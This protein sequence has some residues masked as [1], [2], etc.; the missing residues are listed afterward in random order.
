MLASVLVKL[1]RLNN[2][3][4]YQWIG[5]Q[6]NLSKRKKS[7]KSVHMPSEVLF[8]YIQRD[9]TILIYFTHYQIDP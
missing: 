9:I 8:V 6:H 4:E 5:G 1:R 3:D 7:P 2:S